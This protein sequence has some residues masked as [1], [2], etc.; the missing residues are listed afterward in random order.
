MA[1]A[2]RF[3]HLRE[4]RVSHLVAREG[5]DQDDE[6]G[7]AREPPQAGERGSQPAGATR[8]SAIAATRLSQ[9]AKGAPGSPW[10]KTRA[11]RASAAGAAEEA[12]HGKGHD[13]ARR[14]SRAASS[15]TSRR[16]G[17]GRRPSRRRGSSPAE[18]GGWPGAA[19]RRR[20]ADGGDRAIEAEAGVGLEAQGRA[21]QLHAGRLRFGVGGHE[22][23]LP[24]D[25]NAAEDPRR[26]E[27]QARRGR[28]VPL[29]RSRTLAARPSGS[30]HSSRASVSASGGGSASPRRTSLNARLAPGSRRKAGSARHSSGRSV[31]EG[32][33][34][35]DRRSRPGAGFRRPRRPTLRAAARAP[36]VLRSGRRSWSD[37]RRRAPDA[38]RVAAAAH[39]DP[40]GVVLDARRQVAPDG[41]GTVPGRSAPA[42]VISRARPAT[43]SSRR[44]STKRG[45]PSWT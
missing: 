39:L 11:A 42:S 36:R 4:E 20:P 34:G 29:K 12:I 2:A 35:G 7:R 22:L 16:R 41:H 14:R 38:H 15:A 1:A 6:N 5:H 9:T 10:L 18:R 23:V 28:S 43:S 17:A 33:I 37:G 26:E 32:S 3:G 21:A 27:V 40:Q 30:S 45:M 24:V 19:R 8:C 31:R 44:V 13:R 25:G